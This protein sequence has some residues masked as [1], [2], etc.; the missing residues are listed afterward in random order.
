[1]NTTRAVNVTA[2]RTTRK[3]TIVWADG[4]VSTY[5]FTLLRA[6]CPCAEC[7]GGHENMRST[8]DPAVF[9]VSLGDSPAT[10]L[11]NVEAVGHY[12]LSLEW[13]DGHRFGIY[14]WEYLRA[15][16]PCAKCHPELHHD[17]PAG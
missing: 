9:Q 16:C 5:D 1:M 17:R 15:L 14:T 4:H 6:A 3:M 13:E 7:R 12:A 8:P 11:T 10:W 2:D